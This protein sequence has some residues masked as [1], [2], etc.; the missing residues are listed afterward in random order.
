MKIQSTDE[1][2]TFS[3]TDLEPVVFNA[4]WVHDDLR[5]HAM[6]AALLNRIKDNAAISRK[7]PDG[8]VIDVTEAMRRDKV[9]EMAHHLESGGTDWNLKGTRRPV[10]NATILG[11]AAKRGCTY[12]EAEAWIA[13]EYLTELAEA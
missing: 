5:Q 4:G 2:I 10:Q 7:Q 11:L 8:T 12:E 1:A 3:F 9:V 6:M 13:N